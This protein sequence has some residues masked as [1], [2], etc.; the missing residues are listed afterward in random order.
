MKFTFFSILGLIALTFS[1]NKSEI[2]KKT[3]HGDVSAEIAASIPLT[4]D[5]IGNYHN[6]IITYID[7]E[8][9]VDS[10]DSLSE[11]DSKCITAFIQFNSQYSLGLNDA[12]I[13]SSY[14]QCRNELYNTQNYS[15]LDF[16]SLYTQR[17]QGLL[18][19]PDALSEAESDILMSLFT[20]I[21]A[22][23]KLSKDNAYQKIKKSIYNAKK[24][25]ERLGLDDKNNQGFISG[26]TI[27]VAS[28]SLELW[29]NYEFTTPNSLPVWV[30]LD[31]LGA[32]AGSAGSL[33]GDYMNGNNLN[34]GNAGMQGLVWGV[35][36]SIPSTRPF[37]KLFF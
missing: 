1:C 9:I 34:W 26:L 31:A 19:V 2:S 18:A 22:S 30:G 33:I 12:L 37:K 21:E 27:S 5:L 28:N 4:P 32:L 20:D 23:K 36:A 7:N 13:K 25:I 10:K 8:I 35:T 16:P 11:I 3:E 29:Y 24:S 6:K 14:T 15:S 17:T